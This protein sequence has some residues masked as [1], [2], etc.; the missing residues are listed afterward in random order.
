MNQSIRQ[1]PYYKS[2]IWLSFFASIISIYYLVSTRGSVIFPFGDTVSYWATGKL[3]LRGDNPYSAEEVL[4]IQSEIKELQTSPLNEISMNL[5]PPWTIPFT[6]PLGLFEYSTSRLLWLLFHLLIIVICVKTIWSLYGGSSKMLYLSYLVTF[7]FTPTIFVL[8]IGHNSPLILL[9]TVGFLYF[10][11]KSKA[12][13]WNYF[14]AGASVSLATSRP[15]ILYLLFFA[16]LLWIIN[17]RTWLVL[18]G[19]FIMITMLTLISIAYDPQVINHYWITFS[20]YKFGTWATPTIGQFLRLIF[21]L[22][23]EWLQILPVTFGFAWLFYYW[24][25]HQKTW[26]WLEQMPILLFVSVITSPYVWTYDLVVLLIPVIALMANISRLRFSWQSALIIS[27]FI[28][29]NIIVL[30]S[31]LIYEDF[32]FVWFSPVLL[33]W[34]LIGKKITTH[35]VGNLATASDSL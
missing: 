35:L 25:K 19:G 12:T 18:F 23:K 28:L 4:L 15:Q 11:Q 29:I 20:N 1:S 31:H 26:D 33:I 3:I 14:L 10:T 16:L 13:P 22:E 9:G 2:I 17:K 32:W 24:R 6:I 5:Y 30:Y 21:G 8:M 7:L 27:V 34:Y